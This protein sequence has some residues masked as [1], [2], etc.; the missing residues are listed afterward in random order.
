MAAQ[1]NDNGTMVQTIINIGRQFGAGGLQVAHAIGDSLGIQVYDKE[2]LGK[3]AEKSGFSKEFFEKKD[4][5]KGFRL[6][7]NILGTG[8]D[9]ELSQNYINDD[10]LFKIQSAV[11]REIAE[12]GPAI[13]VGRAANYI[14]RDKDCLDVFICAPL[15]DRIKRV[16]ERLNIPPAEAETLITK[17]EHE[18]QAYYNF[19]TFGEWGR[20]S[21]YDL[22]LNSSLMG[23]KATAEFIIT[24]GRA[25]GLVE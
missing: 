11:I 3:A 23:I 16:A 18:R 12:N 5:K 14:L 17:K 22:C 21:D 24:F 4:E 7:H 13:F 25:A 10:S 20:S 9:A 19:F 2:L 8:R 6:F 15:A 1:L